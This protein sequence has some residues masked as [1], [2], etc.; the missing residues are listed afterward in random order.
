M[1][2]ASS[3]DLGQVPG[4]KG[5][6]LRALQGRFLE[7]VKV[8]NLPERTLFSVADDL[9]ADA[10]AIAAQADHAI[11]LTY[12]A[13]ATY[14][15]LMFALACDVT[16]FGF[17]PGRT[18]HLPDNIAEIR[19]YC[20]ELL[21][22]AGSRGGAASFVDHPLDDAW[23]RYY[24]QDAQGKKIALG[25]A[26]IALEFL[27][28]HELGHVC[29]GHV[30]FRRKGRPR[31]VMPEAPTPVK[32]IP[33]DQR[34]AM[35]WDADTTAARWL[36][37]LLYQDKLLLHDVSV[38]FPDP[39]QRLV[40]VLFALMLTLRAF[41]GWGEA[42]APLSGEYPH[43]KLRVGRIVACIQCAL[44]ALDRPDIDKALARASETASLLEDHLGLSIYPAS[45]FTAGETQEILAELERQAAGYRPAF[46]PFE[47]RFRLPNRAGS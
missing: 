14:A 35:E 43:P 39:F 5:R 41:P 11:T 38:T 22:A 6:V 37:Y 44:S 8:L 2:T 27:L 4:N 24:P 45:D 32:V 31:Y 25:M 29:K 1:E 15:H 46:Q 36:A 33:V 17:W 13:L 12:G 34:R 18:S 47:V 21:E 40:S 19:T 16:L 7:F 20:R 23:L 3:L 28:L 42:V 9:N 30:G 10:Y 26:D